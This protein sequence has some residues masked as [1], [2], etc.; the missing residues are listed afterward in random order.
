MAHSDVDQYSLWYR[1]NRCHYKLSFA[2]NKKHD[3]DR[4]SCYI[5]KGVGAFEKPNIDWSHSNVKKYM[6]VARLVLNYKLNCFVF[7]TSMCLNTLINV[8]YP[9]VP[10]L[11]KVPYSSMYSTSCLVLIL[12]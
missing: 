5:W 3:V 7:Y 10:Y 2:W 6:T 11:L 8:T 1:L 9:T 4:P 12:Q